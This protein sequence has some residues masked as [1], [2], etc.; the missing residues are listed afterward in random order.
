VRYKVE[1]VQFRLTA[2]SDLLTDELS[3]PSR[4]R[5]RL[6]YRCFGADDPRWRNS[7][8]DPFGASPASY[9]LMDDLRAANRLTPCDV[10]LAVVHWRRAEIGFVD[11][12]SV[13]RRITAPTAATHFP[14]WT[15]DRRQA[16]G[17]AM[18][19][20]FHEH[21]H[22]LRDPRS[23]LAV[24]HFR[25]LPPLGVVQLAN[26]RFA[27]GFNETHFLDTISRRE[28]LQMEG[29]RLAFLVKTSFAYPPVDI[30]S[31]VMLWVYRVRENSEAI[32][33]NSPRPP[34]PYL[35]F[36]SG[37]MPPYLGDA[38][39]DVNRWGYSHAT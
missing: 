27:D 34:Q 22:D 32:L 5:N 6:A 18:F 25:Y 16:E 38:H 3:D 11:M 20:Q 36:T 30:D 14:H 29:A 7:L 33:Q 8:R 10:P 13:R 15:G 28:S 1:A 12:W 26:A 19:M 39:F 2:L 9:G 37:H 31:G 23:V 17:E 21:L 24:N 35:V 4:L